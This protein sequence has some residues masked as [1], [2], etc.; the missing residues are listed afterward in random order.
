M[1]NIKIKHIA[2]IMLCGILMSY[3]C[4][5]PKKMTSDISERVEIREIRNVG[6]S[7]DIYSIVDSSRRHAIK[8]NYYKINYSKIVNDT[9]GRQLIESI[10]GVIMTDIEENANVHRT[11]SIDSISGE[12]DM[13]SDIVRKEM[14][15]VAPAADPYRWRYIFGISVVVILIGIAVWL[16][17]KGKSS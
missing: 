17:F 8:I 7:T 5:T 14:S 2:V 4:R 12:V 6:R 3:G 15:S 9:T 13:R 16:R 1:M 10:E 11:H